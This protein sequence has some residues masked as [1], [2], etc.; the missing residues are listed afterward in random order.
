M[1]KEKGYPEPLLK[2]V[3]AVSDH[4]HA[5]AV[6]SR[7]QSGE[8]RNQ[9]QSYEAQNT[10]TKQ[11]QPAENKDDKQSNHGRRPDGAPTE[12][13]IDRYIEERNEARKAANYKRADEIREFLKQRGVVLMDDKGARGNK[14]GNQVTKWRYWNP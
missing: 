6:P 8:D 7:E 10:Y 2:E 14:K 3:K 1:C 9:F 12:D 13:E 5:S 4:P 11:Q